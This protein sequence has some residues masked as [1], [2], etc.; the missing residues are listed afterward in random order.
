MYKSGLIVFKCLTVLVLCCICS[1]IFS[2]PQA[3]DE[4]ADKFRY[5]SG[6]AIQ[7]KLYLHTDKD[8]YVAGE[9]AWF[10]IYYTNGITHQ[11]L[12]MSKVAYVEIL[13]ERNEPVQQAK[14]SLIPGESKGS[15]YLPAALNTG[16]YTIRAYT[17]WMKNFDDGFFFEKRIAIVNTLK[18]SGS[19]DASANT[20]TLQFFPEGGNLV[21]DIECR[22]GFIVRNMA[23]GINDAKGYIIRNSSDTL[24]SF[25]PLKFG[26]GS[27]LFKPLVGNTYKA[28]VVLPGGQSINQALPPIYN[29]GYGMKLDE[30]ATGQL[31]VNVMKKVTG[32]QQSE[33]LML[34]AHTRQSL[35]VAEKGF[36]NNN[37]ST[38]FIIDRDKL[39]DGITHLTLFNGAGKPVCERL[40]FKRPAQTVSLSVNSDRPEYGTREPI[41]LGI[42][43]ISGSST[44]LSMDL[45]ASIFLLD[46]LQ[47]LSES[48]IVDYMWLTSD[49]GGDIES[50][51][52]YFSNDKDVSAATDN[53]MLTHGWRRFKWEEV[54]QGGEAFIKYLP[55]LNGHLVTGVIKDKRT[56]FSMPGINGYLSISGQPFGFYAAK[57]DKYGIVR[58]E[59]K[60][61]YGN[62]Q[63]IAQPGIGEDSFYRVEIQKPFVNATTGRK[64]QQYALSE[65]V[66]D[67]L[68]RKSIGMQVQNIYSGDSLKNFSDPFIDDTLPFYG[69]PE[70]TYMLDDYKRFTTMEEVLREYVREIGVGARHEQLIF[71]IFNP[72]AH[73][74]YEGNALVLLDGVALANPNKI[75]AYDPLKIKRIDVIR[76]RYVMGLSTFNGVASFSTYEGMFDGFEL[77]PGLVAIDYSGLQLQREFYSPAYDTKEQLQRRIPD[78]RN[79]LYWNGDIQTGKNGKTNLRVYS[80]DLKGKYI[81][82]VQGMNETGDFVSATTTFEIK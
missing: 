53:L 29:D 45:S 6:K 22:V 68:L 3:N 7:E 4:V 28:I 2:Q 30:T 72:I 46:S 76:D 73:D 47:G 81:V 64:M 66:K 60:R 5:Y 51:G 18:T 20:V 54:L 80:S 14:I 38:A 32:A 75:F 69:R 44:D 59:V 49:L 57:S 62:S 33:Q 71:K 70:N 37:G 13:N 40:V 21:N 42:N 65:A 16:Y 35:K 36:V 12:R 82:V 61:Y 19:G 9:I 8:F 27:F 63:V 39:G 15:F 77:D 48:S 25:S 58:F 17:N 34:A 56:G 24:F 11:P 50:P 79:T 41:S 55:E 1:H 67:Q 10:R 43:T 78:F 23:G 26:I 31:K 74:F 52:Y